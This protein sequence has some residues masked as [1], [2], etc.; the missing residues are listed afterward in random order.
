MSLFSVLLGPVVDRLQV[1]KTLILHIA[2]GLLSK[3]ILAFTLHP[4]AVCVVLYGPLSICMALGKVFLFTHFMSFQ[5]WINTETVVGMVYFFLGKHFKEFHQVFI[6][7]FDRI[8][9]QIVMPSGSIFMQTWYI[10]LHTTNG[11]RP[12]FSCYSSVVCVIR[13]VKNQ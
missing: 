13:H 4:I 3:V 7:E 12:A 10:L 6:T 8:I 11:T 2:L 9:R 1:R 5:S